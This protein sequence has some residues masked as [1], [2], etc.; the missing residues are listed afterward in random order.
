[1]ETGVARVTASENISNQF[2]NDEEHQNEKYV[3]DFDTYFNNRRESNAV[4]LEQKYSLRKFKSKNLLT[5]TKNYLI[6]NYKPSPG[7]MKLFLLDRIPFLSWFPNYKIREN[8][9]TDVVAGLTIGV[10]QI[11]QGMAYSLMAGL[12]PIVGL[13]VSLWS[14]LAYCFLGSSRHLSLGNEAVT[15]IMIN[16]ALVKLE[17]K[18]FINEEKDSFQSN[19]TTSSSYNVTSP[20]KNSCKF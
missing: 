12:P 1:M 9:F 20:P 16:A 11:P 14:V 7:C 13:Y 8:L 15:A 19:Q 10:V 6:K 3:I 17:G 5:S 2:K 18:Y 4:I